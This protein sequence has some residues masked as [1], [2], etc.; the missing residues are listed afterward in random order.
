MLT[1]FLFL[2]LCFT[3]VHGNSTLSAWS[4]DNSGRRLLTGG[5][6]GSLKMWNFNNGQCL[7]VFNGFGED[8]I[9]CV[10]YVQEG[11]NKYVAAGG[12]N[13]KVS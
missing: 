2:C 11:S 13:S 12:W 10:A 7:K 4:F 6:D 8:E 3:Q 9:T 1:I 5:Q